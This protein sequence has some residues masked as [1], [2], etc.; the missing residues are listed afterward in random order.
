M[1]YTHINYVSCYKIRI[2]IN[3]F[4][5]TNE[6]PP[7]PAQIYIYIYIMGIFTLRVNI[8]KMNYNCCNDS[9]V[10]LFRV[11]SKHSNLRLYYQ[12]G[13]TNH[14]IYIKQK[15]SKCITRNHCV[16]LHLLVTSH[17]WIVQIF[18]FLSD[19]KDINLSF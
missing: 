7:M 12:V 3:H 13:Y 19:F 2:F 14:H 5:M 10:D 18:S 4:W 6:E 9:V 17:K 11:L 8:K 15:V 1:K 16:T